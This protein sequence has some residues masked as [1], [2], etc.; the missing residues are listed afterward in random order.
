MTA[1]TPAPAGGAVGVIIGTYQRPAMLRAAIASVAAQT[2]PV[3]RIIVC[4]DGSGD[5]TGQV[6]A[7]CAKQGAGPVVWLAG[8]HTG[9]PG[10]NRNQALGHLDG[11]DWVAFLDD[12]DTWERD[13]LARQ[14]ARLDEGGVD[15]LGCGVTAI[16]PDGAV[17]RVYRPA[18]GEVTL[19]SLAT[20]NPFATSGVILRRQLFSELGGFDG[21]PRMVGWGD[22]YDLWIRAAARGARLENL[23]DP[24]VVYREGQGIMAAVGRDWDQRAFSLA[25]MT[26]GLPGHAYAAARRVLWGRHHAAAA[27]AALAHRHR[28]AAWRHALQAAAF[29]PSRTAW[30][31]LAHVGRGRPPKGSRFNN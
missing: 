4:D 29:F 3:A 5:E 14:L 24:L 18:T 6:V 26:Q 25:R 20:V 19:V 8:A 23:A 11:L 2:H 22:D 12:D 10:R 7:E 1:L 16:G 27:E 21:H 17:R 31:T 28:L 30:A 9:H 15:L 13:K